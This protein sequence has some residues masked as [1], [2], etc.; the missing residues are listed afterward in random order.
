MHSKKPSSSIPQ[1]TKFD[2]VHVDSVPFLRLPE[3]RGPTAINKDH[4]GRS[5]AASV[6]AKFKRDIASCLLEDYLRKNPTT[7]PRFTRN[8]KYTEEDLERHCSKLADKIRS[9]VAPTIS[10]AVSCVIE[11]RGFIFDLLQL[12]EREYQ[13]SSPPLSAQTEPT[14]MSKSSQNATNGDSSKFARND[15]KDMVLELSTITQHSPGH[16]GVQDVLDSSSKH[17]LPEVPTASH[18]KFVQDVGDVSALKDCDELSEPAPAGK[19][20]KLTW[21]HTEIEVSR[22]VT[23]HVSDWGHS[24]KVESMTETHVNNFEEQPQLPSDRNTT[25]HLTEQGQT[26]ATEE[27]QMSRENHVLIRDA[28]QLTVEDDKSSSNK[29]IINRGSTQNGKVRPVHPSFSWDPIH[30]ELVYWVIR[31]RSSDKYLKDVA[32]F[33]EGKCLNDDG[34]A[35]FICQTKAIS[36]QSRATKLELADSNPKRKVLQRFKRPKYW[37]KR[38]A[39]IRRSFTAMVLFCVSVGGLIGLSI[40]IGVK[41]GEDFWDG[42][43]KCLNLLLTGAATIV[44]ALMGLSIGDRFFFWD[45]IRGTAAVSK[46]PNNPDERKAALEAICKEDNPELYIAG[47]VSWMPGPCVGWTRVPSLVPLDEI[48]HGGCLVISNQKFFANICRSDRQIYMFEDGRMVAGEWIPRK[49]PWNAMIRARNAVWVSPR[50]L[51][52]LT[53]AAYQPPVSSLKSA[54]ASPPPI[55][56]WQSLHSSGGIPGENFRKVDMSGAPAPFVRPD[57]VKAYRFPSNWAQQLDQSAL[58][59]EQRSR[60]G[61]L[62]KLLRSRD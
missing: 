11:A 61:H 35:R 18:K 8:H 13:Q 37:C 50:A 2:G 4:N 40:T 34:L 41:N 57:A 9:Q 19:R 15:A 5:E 25:R 55:W 43:D 49:G 58:P 28:T 54:S 16:S 36:E 32:E 17:L 38:G 39:L 1:S 62:P 10:R 23:S 47:P 33:L 51:G 20:E 29:L 44:L 12:N 52:D 48:A 59:A 27:R 14:Q 22:R 21:P 30:T 42:A 31:S 3:A 53:S 6:E 46:V 45:L 24:E 60:G 56:N 7:L 26:H